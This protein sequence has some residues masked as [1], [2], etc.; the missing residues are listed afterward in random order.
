MTEIVNN[1][2]MHGG[3]RNL[4]QRQSNFEL[5]RIISMLMILSLH[6]FPHGILDPNLVPAGSNHYYLGWFLETL[7]IVG[8]NIFTMIA[9]W[10]LCNRD[11]SDIRKA[12]LLY[13]KMVIYDLVLFIPGV[14]FN[15]TSFSK[16]NIIL[17]I[18]P[19]LDGRHWYI[20][21]YILLLFLYPF[22]NFL[23]NRI[24]QRAFQI[25]LIF[26]VSVFSLWFTFLSSAPIQDWGYGITTF[27]T[28]YL[29]V[30]YIKLYGLN[31]KLLSKMF[32]TKRGLA[33]VYLF[34]SSIS[35]LMITGLIRGGIGFAFR[36][37]IAHAYCSIW[38]IVAA[39]SIFLLFR[40]VR[41][42]SYKWINWLA[43]L[44]MGVSIVH[45][46]YSCIDLIYDKIMHA[47]QY[48]NS[49]MYILI[50]LVQVTLQFLASGLIVWLIDIPINFIWE[51]LE[52]KPL[53]ITCT[54]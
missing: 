22:L 4:K 51:K 31:N 19:F 20:E 8:P 3:N 45:S 38:V 49:G 12:L 34:A 50:Y 2:W 48:A 54:K 35:F 23:I 32:D 6:Y 14:I 41:M 21:T 5:L 13:I 42:R 25:L 27:V 29:I 16:N 11:K 1:N 26:W 43:A 30:A 52:M 39:L 53:E 33:L 17:L 7:C 9:A 24:S 40:K 15:S 44:T 37:D 28:C 47:G 46:N 10:F 18:F 36:N